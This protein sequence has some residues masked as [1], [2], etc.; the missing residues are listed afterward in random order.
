MKKS[1]AVK[2][3]VRVGLQLVQS[4]V[5]FAEYFLSSSSTHVVGLYFLNPLWVVGA[6]SCEWSVLPDQGFHVWKS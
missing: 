5:W 3:N 1:K 4:L 2:K 6:M